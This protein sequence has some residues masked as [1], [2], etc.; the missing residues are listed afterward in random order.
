MTVESYFKSIALESE[1]WDFVPNYDRKYA[2]SSLGRVVSFCRKKPK[3]LSPTSQEQNG[4][5]Y[6]YVCLQGKKVR[7]HRLVALTL[8]PNP[9]GYNEIDHINNNPQDNRVCNLKW[10]TH[11]ENIRNP[12]TVEKHREH[13]LKHPFERIGG[14]PRNVDLTVF[15][16]RHEDKMKAV[17]QIKDGEIVATYE[18]LGEAERKGY[19]KTS[20]SAALHG[21]LKT[22]RGCKWVLVADLE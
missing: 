15:Y 20:I 9:N 6:L 2:V 7:V 14:C 5:A 10:C 8:I 21:R 18:S 3:L 19:K 17:A 22:Y 16:N 1:Q 12:H 11:A 13:L 4:R